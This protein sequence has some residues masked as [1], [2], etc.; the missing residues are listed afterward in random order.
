VR[1]M[2]PFTAAPLTTAPTSESIAVSMF[3]TW[4]R[5]QLELAHI[6]LTY[7]STVKLLA[8]QCSR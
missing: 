2:R 6:G 7:W 4:M 8:A 3:I 1:S 5:A